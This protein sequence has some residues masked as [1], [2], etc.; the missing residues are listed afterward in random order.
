MDEKIKFDFTKRFKRHC[1]FFCEMGSYFGVLSRCISGSDLCLKWSLLNTTWRI[2]EEGKNRN[3]ETSKE[4]LDSSLGQG[5]Q[6]KWFIDLLIDW[7]WEK[8]GQAF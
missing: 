2:D 5:V 1:L 8:S 6:T 3:R 7:I 4:P